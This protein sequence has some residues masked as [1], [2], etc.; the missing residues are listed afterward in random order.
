MLKEGVAL[1]ARTWKETRK[2]LGWSPDVFFTHQV[3]SAHRKAM[4][5]A[6][7]LDPSKDF[8][9]F[10]SLGNMGASAIGMTLAMGARAGRIAH[11]DKVACLGIG[12]GL[13][14]GMLGLEWSREVSV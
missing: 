10:K 7:E 5:A 12:S 13:V 6:L 3:G 9:T 4:I 1:A 14:C 8:A 11:G 2:T